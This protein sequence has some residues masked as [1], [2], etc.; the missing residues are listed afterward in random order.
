VYY[1]WYYYAESRDYV[2]L[3]KSILVAISTILAGSLFAGCSQ[4]SNY[5]SNGKSEGMPTDKFE[6]EKPR[7]PVTLTMYKYYTNITDEQVVSF[8]T[9]PLEKKYANV[10]FDFISGLKKNN[11]D[12][13]HILASG[14]NPDLIVTSSPTVYTFQKLEM[15]ANLDK[16]IKEL[17]FDLNRFDPTTI[18]ALKK[19]SDHGEINAIPFA[20]DPAALFYNQDIFDKFGVLYPEEELTWDDVMELAKK[21]TRVS[22]ETLFRGV[23]PPNAFIL[24]DQLSLGYVNKKTNKSTV[25]TDQWKKVY[26]LFKEF[27]NIPGYQ[28]SQH[29]LRR[30]KRMFIQDK[31]VAM[32]PFWLA[33][34]IGDFETM[35]K[36]GD[37]FAWNMT[38][39]PSFKEAPGQSANVDFQVLM[40]SNTSKHKDLVFDMIKYL[41]SDEQQAEL[42]RNGSMT[43]LDNKGMKATFGANM[44][45]MKGKNI[46][47]IIKNKP[48][49]LNPSEYD[50]MISDLMTSY[51]DQ[52]G[53][54]EKD[55]N[56]ALRE[57]Q[58]AADNAIAEQLR[59]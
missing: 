12:A 22:D 7:E 59:K 52:I 57:L 17:N 55:I 58:E 50:L 27:Y 10:T 20:F 30:G 48:A 35:E 44:N 21:L 36:N 37:S 15:A 54:G 49:K 25:N 11:T 14:V 45:V 31:T 9:A 16:L 51:D 46:A 43:V 26:T 41:T 53:K 39:Y 56:T 42:T 4:I 40:V 13:E 5:E 47:S 8:I 19:F 2:M 18:D 38:T 3:K 32:L 29:P 33:S 28:D 1:G 6:V 34:L 23:V 24:G